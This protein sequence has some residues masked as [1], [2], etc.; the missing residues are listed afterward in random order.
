MRLGEACLH[1]AKSTRGARGRVC[2]F[3][4]GLDALHRRFVDSGA[5]ITQPITVE[6]YHM[7]EFWV[8]D[9]DNNELIFGEPTRA[10]HTHA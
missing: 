7:R 8:A 3:C 5:K 1:L 6:P 10:Q 2:L 9:L 4:T